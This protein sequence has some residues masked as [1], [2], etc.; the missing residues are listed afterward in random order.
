MSQLTHTEGL[1]SQMWN[2]AAL[3]AIAKKTR[4]RILFLDSWTEGKGLKLNIPFEGLP[5]HVVSVESMTDA[6]RVAMKF[7]IDTTKVVDSRVFE[8]DTNLNYDFR[9]G[10]FLSY[11]YW[12][13]IRE[14]LF[15][16]FR[17][18]AEIVDQATAVLG[19]VERKGREV[20]ALHVRR[21]DY[22]ESVYAVN[23]SMDYYASACALFD[24]DRHAFLVFSD[25][26]DW[27]KREFGRRK[28]FFFAEQNTPQVDLCAMSLCDHNIVA[29]SHFGSWG[30][31]LNKNKAKKV[32]CP[33]KYF[34][35]DGTIFYINNAW[36]PDEWISLDDLLA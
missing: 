11:R 30:A 24:D 6:E 31:L 10:L 25:D 16:I 3:Y 5:L 1:G 32:V 2:F 8:I 29:N 28:N 34:K 26:L 27:C 35:S 18:K 12:Y 21:G 23:L 36:F 9:G 13:P 7:D 33:A 14:E 15:K 20:V 19:R 22:L 17:F 4:H